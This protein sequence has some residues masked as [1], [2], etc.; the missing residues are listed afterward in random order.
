MKISRLAPIIAAAASLAAFSSAR[1]D[2]VLNFLGLQNNEEVLDYYNGGLG[3]NGSGPGPNYGITFGTD[4]LALIQGTDGGTGNFSNGPSDTIIYFL[5]G[6]GD[7]MNVAA[8]FN[9]G[10][11][12]DYVSSSTGSVSVYS[13]QNGTGSLLGTLNLSSTPD[14]YN[15]WEPIGVTFGGTAESVVFTGAANGIGFDDI[16]LGSATAGAVPDNASIYSVL[17]AGLGLIASALAFRRK[18][19]AL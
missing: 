14:P 9:T 12:F 5:S 15:V 17:L 11:S 2:V 7:V 19:F 8:G 10:F 13:G 6:P 18:Q 1:A 4:T 16:T 3:G